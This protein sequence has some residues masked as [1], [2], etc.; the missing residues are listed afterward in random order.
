[1]P[2]GDDVFSAGLD[3]DA[4]APGDGDAP[5]PYPP[6]PAKHQHRRLS[7]AKA[8]LDSPPAFEYAPRPGF[9][10]KKSTRRISGGRKREGIKFRPLEDA[11][12]SSDSDSDAD[13][14][15]TKA[16][17]A[18]PWL[19]HATSAA[20]LSAASGTTL[21][22]DLAR[23]KG[24]SK[25]NGELDVAKER[26]AL[27]ARKA[28]AADDGAPDYSDY[29]S[30]G[31]S[32][33]S[34]AR[35]RASRGQPGWQPDFLR[36]GSSGGLTTPRGSAGAGAPSVLSSAARSVPATPSLIRAIDRLAAAQASAYGFPAVADGGGDPAV[37][38][39]HPPAPAAEE[40]LG[41]EGERRAGFWRDVKAKAA[42]R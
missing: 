28:G 4:K 3:L 16:S 34:H 24:D 33:A 12:A 36:G 9:L 35:R 2:G 17:V 21:N 23:G 29:E 38:V 22:D 42:Q 31:G 13:G 19:A 14:T 20:S 7:T 32:A 15:L 6:R 26:A 40:E 41:A 39:P 10:Q 37:T 8:G 27:A 11:D 18:K 30:D 1:V 25:D 5:P